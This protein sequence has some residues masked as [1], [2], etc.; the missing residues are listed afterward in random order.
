MAKIG[1]AVVGCGAMAQ[2]THLPN[3]AKHPD[4]ELLWLCDVN[5]STLRRAREKFHARGATTDAKEVAA[6]AKCEAVLVCTT[7]TVRLPLIELFARAGKHIFVEKPFADS[8]D[9]MKRVIRVVKET[10]IRFTVGHNRRMAPATREAL[11]I[12]TKHRAKPVSPAWR[13]DR[14]GTERPTLPDEKCPLCP[15]CGWNRCS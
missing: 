14:E 9:E 3:I 7:Q 10:G 11:R 12:L 4:L 15:N 1:I 2:M 6:D 8:F 13:W 5:E